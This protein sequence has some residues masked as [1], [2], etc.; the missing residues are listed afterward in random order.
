MNE[1]S[2]SSNG[3][4]TASADAIRSEIASSVI[5]HAWVIAFPATLFLPVSFGIANLD[6]TEFPILSTFSRRDAPLTRFF[7]LAARRR[8]DQGELRIAAG[9]EPSRFAALGGFGPGGLTEEEKRV[10]KMKPVGDSYG[11]SAVDERI[12]GLEAHEA[13]QGHGDVSN[14]YTWWALFDTVTVS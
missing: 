13:I 8:S 12:V 9:G 10:M 1:G 7:H 14:P 2:R 5:R 11:L 3:P 4:S 6:R